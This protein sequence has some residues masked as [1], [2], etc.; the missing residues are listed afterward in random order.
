MKLAERRRLCPEEEPTSWS[1][2][3]AFPGIHF[4]GIIALAGGARR[5]GLDVG[6]LGGR[7]RK[8]TGLREEVDWVTPTARVALKRMRGEEV[9]WLTCEPANTRQI[10]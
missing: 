5:L 9:G 3:L 2:F 1:C 8:R 6:R 10:K 4:H 7:G